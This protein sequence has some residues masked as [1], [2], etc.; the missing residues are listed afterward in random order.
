MWRGMGRDR[1]RLVGMIVMLAIFTPF[2]IGLAVVC[3]LLATNAPPL[4]PVILRAAFGFAYLLW[5]ITPLLG[6][7]LNEAYDPTRLFI[8]P[9]SYRTIFLAAVVGGCFDLTTLLFLP[10]FIALLIA[11]SHSILAA[12]ADLIL[13]ALFLLQTIATAQALMLVLIGFL[14]SRRFRDITMVLLPLIGMA[15]Y[16]AQQT[17]LHRIGMFS[18]AFRSLVQS[19]I[20]SA[21]SWLPP[22]WVSSGMAAARDGSYG[23]ALL[24]MIL[25]TGVCAA[26]AYA[27]AFVMRQLYLGDR[28][29]VVKS[30]PGVAAIADSSVTVPPA[31]IAERDLSRPLS[32]GRRLITGSPYQ[33]GRGDEVSGARGL[34]LLP[35]GLAAVLQKEWRYMWRE[36]QYKVVAIQMVYTLA[37]FG[38]AFFFRNPAFSTLYS[39]G[40]PGSPVS[41]LAALTHLWVP[42]L[43]SGILL[44][45]S[46]QLVFNIFG[47]E[48]AAITMLFS[49]PT[50]RRYFF[51][52]KN[53][54]HASVVFTICVI[55]I[56]AG[57]YLTGGFAVAPLAL[58]WV[59]VA[60]PVVLAAGN[61][62][63][64][65]FPHRMVVR[66]QRWGRSNQVTLSAA[67]GG[68]GAGCGYAFVYLACYLATFIALVPALAGVVIPPVFDLGLGWRVLGVSAAVLYAAGL[69]LVCLYMAST[70]VIGR[71]SAIIERLVPNE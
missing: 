57:C 38:M 22:G 32:E 29:P 66:G 15:W 12:L 30:A 44:L 54:A 21:L 20:W 34:G 64:I 69:Y 47:G 26:M 31:S 50:P 28:G 17:L 68:G 14:R 56:L 52:G 70:W 61:L 27:A 58:L 43:I 35:A 13:I 62:V 7:P 37:I 23:V 48:G 46:L 45:G 19:P 59:V 55:G 11:V 65:R 67:G 4:A 53:L 49:F 24:D 10:V 60:L 1:M 71:E 9:I 41:P 5:L 40:S 36:P 39:G 42:F 8:Y 6:F 33:E 25:L 51:L 18:S 63:S 16:I 2:S 3:W